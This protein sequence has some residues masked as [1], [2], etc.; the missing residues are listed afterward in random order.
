MDIYNNGST[1][2]YKQS[3]KQEI[4][5]VVK[6]SKIYIFFALA[7]AL[8]GVV[9]FT[10]PYLYDYA[11]YNNVRLLNTLLSLS[12]SGSILVIL[13]ISIYM[14]VAFR[15]NREGKSPVLM[16]IMFALYA[17][18]FG[19]MIGT[20]IYAIM[21]SEGTRAIQIVGYTFLI[22]GGI[23][24]ICGIIGSLTK[25]MSAVL[26]ISSGVIL[27]SLAL[28]LLNIFLQSTLISWLLSF[29]FLAFILF[30][31]AYDL[32]IINRIAGRATFGNPNITAMFCA[33]NIYTD[34]IIIFIRLLY[35]A[36]ILFGNR[37]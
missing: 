4:V 24:L 32:H 1:V 21:L 34:F 5:N 13:P 2:A 23:F 27:G 17:T 9:A 8:T 16:A 7:L 20:I 35:I 31:T 25:D 36:F 28:V 33:F 3:G 14:S 12:M 30:V 22:S 26:S 18:F 37:K 29:V 11:L 19:L 15:R 6:K 10:I